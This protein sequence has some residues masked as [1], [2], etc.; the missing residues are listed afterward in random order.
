MN[1]LAQA[2]YLATVRLRIM[3]LTP[4]VPAKAHWINDDVFTEPIL[5]YQTKK[6]TPESVAFALVDA[7]HSVME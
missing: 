3:E 2:V 4:D 5:H 1:K 7:Y 6:Y